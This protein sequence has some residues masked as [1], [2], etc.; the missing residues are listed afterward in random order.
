[1]KIGATSGVEVSRTESTWVA[2]PVSRAMHQRRL[3][4]DMWYV[5][6]LF[7]ESTSQ[8]TTKTHEEIMKLITSQSSRH[9][10]VSSF[11]P[12]VLLSLLGTFGVVG[13]TGNSSS[14]C[15]EG[16][17][18]SCRCSDDLPGE[19]L[20]GPTGPVG[21]CRCDGTS[22]DGSTGTQFPQ[23]RQDAQ[24]PSGPTDAGACDPNG[25]PCTD[26][27]SCDGSACVES[28][29]DSSSPNDAGRIGERDVNSPDRQDTTPPG[30]AD[31]EPSR[32]D[33][34]PGRPD[35]EPG[36]PDA[37]PSRPDA[38]PSRPDAEPGRPDD[39]GVGHPDSVPQV[40]AR[41]TGDL[42]YGETCQSGNQCRSGLCM[43]NAVRSTLQCTNLCERD[44]DCP[45]IDTCLEVEDRQG[46][47]ARA[48]VLNE[49]GTPCQNPQQC[50]SGVCL[51]PPDP[52]PWVSIQA[53][54]AAMCPGDHKC[55]AGYVCQRTQSPSGEVQVC[56]PNVSLHSCLDGTVESCGGVCDV[57]P[58]IERDVTRC[59]TTAEGVAGYCTCVC[60]TGAD[61]PI[62]F[63][64]NP[65]DTGDPARPGVCLAMAGYR[66]A[67]EAEDPNVQQCPSLTCVAVDDHISES[68][69]SAICRRDNDCPEDYQCERIDANN[70]VCSV[71]Q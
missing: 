10:E 28:D 7:H 32:P 2:D 67:Q 46:N 42:E 41:E 47:P 6:I 53:I 62:G 30:E 8:M 63:A 39:I 65:M 34:E 49:T 45:G 3:A 22:S 35:A 56:A 44:D 15:I 9:S 60:A 12:G 69:C 52:G 17:V 26:G 70:Q 36:R 55:P 64:C 16:T 19:V 24:S 51:H 48:C 11:L 18:L 61:C 71:R 66:C 14:G 29:S 13:C 21:P 68:Y 43:E 20:C 59:V 5:R 38:E 33:A 27:L 37:E 50:T 1:M 23:P 25:Q 58:E 54:C 31:A 57:A 40:D 4:R